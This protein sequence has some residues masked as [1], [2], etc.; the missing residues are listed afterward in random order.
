M[1]YFSSVS[2]WYQTLTKNSEAYARQMVLEAR[3]RN[4]ANQVAELEQKKYDQTHN[5]DGTQKD[6]GAELDKNKLLTK[7]M[8]QEGA[9]SIMTF[10]LF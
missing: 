3:A 2:A 7:G 6:L 9:P 5:A 8:K 4:L 1:G 10:P